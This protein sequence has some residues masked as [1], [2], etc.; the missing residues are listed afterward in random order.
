[1]MVVIYCKLIS[2]DKNRKNIDRHFCESEINVSAEIRLLT[3]KLF[4]T[5]LF[6]VISITQKYCK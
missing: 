2:Q 4:D 6:Q 1:M 5:H 3:P